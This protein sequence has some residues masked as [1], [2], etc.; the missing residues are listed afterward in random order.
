MAGVPLANPSNV[1]AWATTARGGG[2]WSVGGV[3][4][5]GLNPFIT[6]GN[7]FSASVWG[8]GEAVIRFHSGALFSGLTNDYWAP[9]NWIALDSSD[10]D[11]GGSGPLVVDVPG[12]TPSKLILALGK[13][14]YAYLLNRTNLGGVSLPLAKAHV[15]SSTI[16][17]AAVTYPTT[18]GTYVVLTGNSSQLVALRISASNPPTITNVWTVSEGG[19]GSP[20]VTSTDGT[21]N[22][23]VWGIGSESDQRLHAFSGDTGATVFSG[24]G[25]NE[26]MAGTRRFNTAIV[27]RGRIYVAND[28]RVYAFTV[29]VPPILLNSPVLLPGGAFQFSFT[30]TSG[31]SFTVLGTTN[32]TLALSNWTRL[33]GVQEIAPGQF[34]FNDVQGS[35]NETRFYRVS[36]P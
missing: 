18:N 7:T 2:S 31:L 1:T 28:N 33:G 6:T 3:A 36:S 34:Q 26:L 20:F 8:G 30:N 4:S 21:N 23:I 9:T 13:D 32:L 14:G 25:A 35:S 22:F 27:A 15:S 29:P 10:T 24:G 5:D 19:R 12:A 17:Q 11:I 16:L